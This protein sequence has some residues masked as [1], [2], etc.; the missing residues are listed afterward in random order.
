MAPIESLREFLDP[1]CV[2]ALRANDGRALYFSR[3]P[4][5]WPRDSVAADVR[6]FI[7]AGAPPILGI[8]AYRVRK[9]LLQFFGLGSDAA[10]DYGEARA[11]ARTGARD[12]HSSDDIAALAA[13]GGRHA[14][15]SGARAGAATSLV[16]AQVPL[17][18]FKSEP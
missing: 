3:A 5:P 2:K 18:F 1:N 10:R 12:A 8:Y 15:G 9:H 14:G 11:A 7:R 6:G 4:V 16:R 13:R 17:Y